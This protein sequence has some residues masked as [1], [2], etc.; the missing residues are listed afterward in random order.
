MKQY[1]YQYQ[2][3]GYKVFRESVETGELISCIPLRSET[4]RNTTT[5]EL[6]LRFGINGVEC[7]CDERSTQSYA[8]FAVTD[9]PDWENPLILFD[10]Y[11]KAREW[12]QGIWQRWEKEYRMVVV[13]CEYYE[14]PTP[15]KWSVL[16]AN[17]PLHTVFALWIR[18][19]YILNRLN[20]GCE[21]KQPKSGGP[22]AYIPD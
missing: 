9:C 17:W 15:F 7:R 11:A 10:T 3:I 5:C 4:C 22:Y 21:K 12:A 8:L 1:E 18:P 20:R 16:S 14:A 2:R 19:V 13:E 6:P